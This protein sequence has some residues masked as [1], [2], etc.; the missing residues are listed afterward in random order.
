VVDT[1]KKFN[2]TYPGYYEDA[3]L[4]VVQVYDTGNGMERLSVWPRSAR[5][6]GYTPVFLVPAT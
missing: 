1:A 5:H 4:V 3:A 6:N 2:K